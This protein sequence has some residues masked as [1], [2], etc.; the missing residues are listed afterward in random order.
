MKI[1]E[2]GLFGVGSSLNSEIHHLG[3]ILKNMGQINIF[4]RC[5][6]CQFAFV[7]K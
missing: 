7:S 5:F 2:L 6:F 3:R 4:V 1:N